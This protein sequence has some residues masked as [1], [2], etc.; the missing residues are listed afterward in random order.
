LKTSSS[1]AVLLAAL[2]PLSLSHATLFYPASAVADGKFGTST[3]ILGVEVLTGAPQAGG[4]GTAYL[5]DYIFGSDGAVSIPSLAAPAGATGNL[6]GASVAQSPNLNLVGQPANSDFAAGEGTAWAIFPDASTSILRASNGAAGDAFGTAVSSNSSISLVGAPLNDGAGANAGAAYVYRNYASGAGGTTEAVRLVASD[7]S[8]N[9]NLG[10]AVKI[11]GAD[12]L[13]GAPGALG[14]KGAAYLYQGLDSATG[15]L[16]ESAELT[17]SD[18]FAGDH[19]GSSVS[20]SGS[21]GVVGATGADSGAGAAYLYSGLLNTFSPPST[22]YL[23]ISALDGATGDLF[24]AS[25]SLSGANA[26]V[27]APGANAGRGAAYLYV[28]INAFTGT[29]ETVKITAANGAAGDGFGTSVAL[30][31]GRFV[32]GSPSATYS[33]VKSGLLYA[34]EVRG[35]TTFDTGSTELISIDALHFVSQVDWIIGDTTIDNLVLLSSGSVA[36]VTIP[37]KAVYIGKSAG[38]N[39]NGLQ[40]LGAT[41]VP[42]TIVYIGAAGNSDNAMYVNTGAVI[43]GVNFRLADGNRFVARGNVATAS[44]ALALLGTAQLQV[45]VDGTWTSLDASNF[46]TLVTASYDADADATSIRVAPAVA[47]VPPA[48]SVTVKKPKATSSA[49]VKLT[50]TCANAVTIELK[51]GKSGKHTR[52]AAS[53]TSWS[54]TVKGLKFGKNEVYVQAISASGVVTAAVKVKVTRH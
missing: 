25:V 10:T 20:F 41:I 3:S 53:G 49:K 28:G 17:A 36:D 44:Q 24:G 35:F 9:A 7:A 42:G 4:N 21:Y 45:L 18:G 23:K 46:S 33:G 13:V 30:D 31:N 26:I 8:T 5:G 43:D 6:F 32:I 39:G 38:S 19:L 2:A 27:G 14:G 52:V 16:T 40:V 1:F 11:V 51:V 22:E 54:A 48:P 47:P 50:G 29:T 12:G 34:G 15:S 37:G